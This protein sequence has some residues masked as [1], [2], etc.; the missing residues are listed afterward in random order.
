[1]P[2]GQQQKIKASKTTH[3]IQNLAEQFL[4]KKKL[5][6]LNS[7]R[8]TS[9]NKLFESKKSKLQPKQKQQT[10]SQEAIKEST[11]TAEHQTSLE[12]PT[13]LTLFKSKIKKVL[14]TVKLRKLE[15]FT[16]TVESA[17]ETKEAMDPMELTTATSIVSDSQNNK[18]DLILKDS[19]D[20]D[21]IK[22][23]QLEL[24]QEPEQVKE[25]KSTNT[26]TTV[27]NKTTLTSTPTTTTTIT[28]KNNNNNVQNIEAIKQNV[29]S[30]DIE[31]RIVKS[32]FTPKT[33]DKKGK[34]FN[35]NVWE[36]TQNN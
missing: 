32:S 33:F 14:H 6:S 10:N 3:S 36:S 24:E 15:K 29:N 20:L 30:I 19:S 16:P 5:T 11:T 2:I 25:K 7:L 21:K 17:P 9:M 31:E 12:R 13:D 27:N 35:K 8:Q 28:N 26:K 4:G 22:E 18:T 23:Q 1:M 34:T